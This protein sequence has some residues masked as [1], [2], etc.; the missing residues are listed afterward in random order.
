MYKK[1]T[2]TIV[3]E[4]FSHPM[5]GEIKESLDKKSIS[6]KYKMEQVS[7]DKFRLD[8]SNYLNSLNLRFQDIFKNIESMDD[9]ALA[10]SEKILFSEIDVLGNMYK[11]YY[12]IEFGERLNQYMRTVALLFIAIAKNLKNKMDT[13][14]WRLRLDATKFDIANLFYGYNNIWRL[15]DTQA[16]FGQIFNE[17]ITEAQA[18][19]NKDSSAATRSFESLTNL[20]SVL[21]T[22][23]ANATVQQYPGKFITA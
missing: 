14:D 4:H 21:A 15:P 9:N 12:G 13:R 3:E 8:I 6:S 10:E 5:A 18:I 17:L 20:W 7:A 19:V 1:V 16:L 22:T 23:L 2:H 11:T